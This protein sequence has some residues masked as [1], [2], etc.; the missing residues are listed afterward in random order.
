VS[1]VR[2]SYDAVAERYAE[3]IGSELRAKPLDRALLQIMADAA[4]SDPIADL[5]CGPGHVAAY[6]AGL[7]ASAFGLD[8]SA[9]MCA[10]AHRDGRVPA[11][12][13][14]VR[15]LPLAP[16]SVGAVVCL[17]TLI[18]LDTRSR[19]EAYGELFRI[20]RPGGQALVAFHTFDDDV[21]IGGSTTL[22]VWWDTEVDLTFRFLD[23]D[24][25]ASA[26]VDAGFRFVARLDRAPYVE[27]EHPSHRSYLLVARP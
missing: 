3:E 23:P 10:L 16:G 17:Y 6:L 24:G 4:G 2:R 8:L 1:D 25:E 7:G 14:D 27:V 20:L 12:A 19:A 5:G 26:L 13:G 15:C 22:S 11:V 18:H 21:P 9:R